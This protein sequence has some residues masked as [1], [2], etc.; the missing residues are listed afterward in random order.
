MYEQYEKVFLIL[1][2]MK[3]MLMWCIKKVLGNRNDRDW[4][5]KNC[6]NDFHWSGKGNLIQ[7]FTSDTESYGKLLDLPCSSQANKMTKC[8]D[9]NLRP[10]SGF[11]PKNRAFY[12]AN[13]I[14]Y[15]EII[16]IFLSTSP[17]FYLKYIP[18]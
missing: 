15:R 9:L 4:M 2:L 14:I 7:N 13:L 8:K 17:L 3:I 11:W 6:W 1:L 16:G 18:I 12:R 10:S 5:D